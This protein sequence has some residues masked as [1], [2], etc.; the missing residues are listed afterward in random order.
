MKKS[1]M[2]RISVFTVILLIFSY[3][4]VGCAHSIFISGTE[5]MFIDTSNTNINIDGSDFTLIFRLIGAETNLLIGI[6]VY[7]IYAVIVF[8]VSLVLCIPFRLVGLRKNT[9]ISN[10]ESKITKY[11]FIGILS[12]SIITGLILTR[13]TVIIPLLFYTAIWAV[14]A[15]FI[16][17]YPLLKRAGNSDK[18]DYNAK[19]NQA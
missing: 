17:V 13:F 5:Q 10:R 12:V 8:I 14:I 11:I 18:G 3:F 9:V 15:F 4:S 16:Y 1:G 2:I 19:R 6:F 7:G